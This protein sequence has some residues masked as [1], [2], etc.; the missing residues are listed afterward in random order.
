MM[1]AIRSAGLLSVSVALS[2]V[3]CKSTVTRSDQEN[4][5][6]DT[7][8]VPVEPFLDALSNRLSGPWYATDVTV[9]DAD[10][11]K[12]YELDGRDVTVI[13]SAMPHDRCNPNASHHLS[14]DQAYRVDFVYRTSA[15]E[16]RRVA[17]QKLFE[18][19][20]TVGE[21]LVR[22]EECPD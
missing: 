2:L 16:K 22:V 13:L 9:P 21:R 10:P 6:L 8:K 4:F 15:P 19:A 20:A 18:A 12:H 17:K 11:S 5:V 1:R 7:S 3:G 14:W